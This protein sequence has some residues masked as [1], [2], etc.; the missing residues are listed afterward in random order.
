MSHAKFIWRGPRGDIIEDH[1]LEKYEKNIDGDKINLVMKDV[2][3]EDMGPYPFEV[4][5]ETEDSSQTE[6]ITY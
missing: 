2:S 5:V 3:I 6:N 4:S 1:N